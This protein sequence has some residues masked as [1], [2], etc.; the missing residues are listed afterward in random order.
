M[1]APVSAALRRFALDELPRERW[2]NGGG[3]TRTVASATD[4]GGQLR[5]RVSVADIEAAGP[6]SRFEGLDRSALMLRGGRLRLQGEGQAW[7]FDGP[8]S[9]AQFPGELALQCDA[10]DRPTQLWNV[11]VRRGLAQA[12]LRL[13]R[14]TVTDLPDAPD[15][16]VLVLQGRFDAAGVDAGPHGCSLGPGEGLHRQGTGSA[17]RLLPAE[18]GSL[19]LLTELR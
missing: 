19:L 11:M 4:A 12:R 3:W 13:L 10:P 6:F 7:T 2:K 9:L 16:L 18:P 17:L 14:E 5:W 1:T 15:G 8:G